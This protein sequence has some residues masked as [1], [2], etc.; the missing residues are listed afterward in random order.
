M[1]GLFTKLSPLFHLTRVTMG[2]AAVANVWF[3]LLWSHAM[4]GELERADPRIF[5]DQSIVVLLAGGAALALGLF[6]Y[7]MALNDTLDVRRDRSLHPERPLPAGLISYESAVGVVAVTLMIAVTGAAILGVPAVM[8]TL[9]TAG[10]ILFY[11]TVAR[12][13]PSVGFVALSLIYGSH[14][15]APN[16]RII[17]VWPIWLVMTHAIVLYAITHMLSRRRPRL[18]ITMVL[19]ASLG[20]VFWSYILLVVGYSRA[21]TVWP[22]WVPPS[23]GVIPGVLAIVFIS[24]AI[25]KA[26]TTKHRERTA[27]KLQRY[28]AF[29]LTLYAIGWM[30]GAGLRDEALILSGLAL[31]GLIGMTILREIYGLVEHPVGFRR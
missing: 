26:K 19:S 15:V 10:A 30:A 13:M 6:T 22:E 3:V 1:E 4:P 21:G 8:L 16:M 2:F 27:E 25:Y 17:F 18:T 7:A 12:Y 29:W 23:A 14:M 20:Y 9:L 24:F 31:A 28:G 5:Q 11:Y